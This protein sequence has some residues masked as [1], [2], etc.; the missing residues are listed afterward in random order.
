MP[1]PTDAPSKPVLGLTSEP[2]ARG[3]NRT[4][5]VAG[6]LKVLPDQPAGTGV[7]ASPTPQPVTGIPGSSS[8]QPISPQ[9]LPQRSPLPGQ[10]VVSSP[11]PLGPSSP[12]PPPPRP[13]DFVLPPGS[14]SAEDSDDDEGDDEQEQNQEEEVRVLVQRCFAQSSMLNGSVG[15]GV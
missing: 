4:T 15:A 1:P 3:A 8:T 7:T 5:K 14:G 6:K 10:I 2:K 11:L 9:V 13:R 12:L